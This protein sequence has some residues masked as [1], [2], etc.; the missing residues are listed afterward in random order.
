MIE[1]LVTHAPLAGLLFFF[2]VFVGIAF[3]A[4]KPSR[5]ATLEAHAH[6]PL[7]EDSKL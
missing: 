5:K 2:S 7:K 3:W 6:I 1:T 4:L